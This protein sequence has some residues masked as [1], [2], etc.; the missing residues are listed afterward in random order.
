MAEIITLAG[1]RPFFF[2][3]DSFRE[4]QNFVKGSLV[5][6]S[7]IPELLV[8]VGPVQS[9]KSATLTRV[10]P[11]MISDSYSNIGINPFIV[12][13][14]FVVGQNIETAA[15]ALVTYVARFAKAKLGIAVDVP[16]N[17]ST[18]FGLMAILLGEVAQR[19]EEKGC[20]LWLLLDEAQAPLLAS[21]TAEE[22]RVFTS[23]LKS[24][25]K[26][27]YDYGGR[28]VLTG[29]GMMTFVN[30]IRSAKTNGY[31]FFSSATFVLLGRSL[32]ES[33]AL[34]LAET[35]IQSYSNAWPDDL[36]SYVTAKRM[37]TEI[38]NSGGL[39]NR[40]PALFASVADFIG[41]SLF[42]PLSPIEVLTKAFADA[43][44]K[45]RSE[46]L[47]DL[48][49]VLHHLEGNGNDREVLKILHNLASGDPDELLRLDKFSHRR[50]FV[51]L[52]C[53]N[54]EQG[55][56]LLP[57]YATLILEL[58]DKA[59]GVICK[60]GQVEFKIKRRS[61]RNGGMQK[62]SGRVHFRLRKV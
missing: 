7:N 9:G 25:I 10:L 21:K 4:M 8:L 12:K 55:L 42:K 56:R 52:L 43:E 57:P 14:S 39:L 15:C 54:T 41:N 2:D 33:T 19:V 53:D 44:A 1:G 26:Y 27:C 61:K 3:V 62:W 60:S 34:V 37:L 16:N 13:F 45:I 22:C 20:H 59:G 36:K 18:T 48:L 11:L 35:I 30:E 6:N 28:I 31:V 24:A 5:R 50:I 38:E 58:L 32:S 49:T 17:P 46:S 29:S 47:A 23:Q 51:S 40:R